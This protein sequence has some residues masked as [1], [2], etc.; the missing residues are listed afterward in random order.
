MVEYSAPTVYELKGDFS[1]DDARNLKQAAPKIYCTLGD[2]TVMRF[3]AYSVKDPDSGV[4]LV[5]ISGE[6]N[7][8]QDEYARMRETSNQ[9]TFDDRVVKHEFSRH[10]FLLKRLELNLEFHVVSKE[11]IKKLVLIEK[12]YFKDKLLSEFEFPFPFCMAGSTNTWQYT[13]ELP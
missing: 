7:K 9:L 3:G 11:P 2:N 1:I 12:H 4:T 8:L 5:A 10:F 6:E 13:Y